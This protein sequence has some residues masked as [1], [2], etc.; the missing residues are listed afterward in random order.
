M[1]RRPPRSTLSSS[2]AASDVYKR[3][4]PPRSSSEDDNTA[5]HFSTGGTGV[6]LATSSMGS[7]EGE[8]GARASVSLFR[9]SIRSADLPRSGGNG[10]TSGGHIGGSSNRRNV[11]DGSYMEVEDFNEYM[12]G[13]VGEGGNND[14]DGTELMTL[15]QHC[16][17]YTSPSPRDS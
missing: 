5:F 12:S 13:G 11:V 9:N 8:R 15:S 1:I 3:Q 10:G 2:S 14:D 7:H 4:A 17:L 16:L 6:G